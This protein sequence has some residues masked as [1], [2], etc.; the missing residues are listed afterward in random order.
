CQLCHYRVQIVGSEDKVGT[1]QQGHHHHVQGIGTDAHS[2]DH[3][4]SH[5]HER[6]HD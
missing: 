4:H 2:H 6:S 3:D 1:P 5:S